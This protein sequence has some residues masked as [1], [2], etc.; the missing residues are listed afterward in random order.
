MM[1]RLITIA[2]V[3]VSTMFAVPALAQVY[4]ERIPSVVREK[5]VRTRTAWDQRNNREEQID[6]VTKTVRLGASGQIDLGNIAGDIAITRANGTD[7]TIEVVKTAR[8]R[9]VEDARELLQLVTADIVE[10]AGRVEV[11]AHY[12]DERQMNNRRNINVSVAYT[13]AAPPDTRISANSISGNIRVQDI[14]GD[15]TLES[16]SGTVQITNS[17]R[18][19]TAKSISGNVEIVSTQ[20]DGG[21]EASTVSGTVMA[22]KVKAQRLDLS[23]VSGPVLIEDV[24][25]DRVGARSVSGDIRFLGTLARGGRYSLQSH[26]GEIRLALSGDVGFELS[27]NTFSGSVNAPDFKMTIQGNVGGGRQRGMRGVV[28]DG[29]AV[30]DLT[31]FSGSIAI[32]KR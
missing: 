31:T 19:A 30:L 13:V 11:R 24:T 29:S 23:S 5:A 22:R 25:C 32:V 28:G 6:R 18:I 4:P 26:S 16:I 12:P 2:A 8:G 14:Q 9:T 10:R 7:A 17:G 20:V 27:A 3:A 15:L 21:V 1:Q